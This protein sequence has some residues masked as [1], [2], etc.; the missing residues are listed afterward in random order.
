MSNKNN[1]VYN[2]Q[3]RLIQNMS[4]KIFEIIDK[5]EGARCEK[6]GE[7]R[8][9]ISKIE[10]CRDLIRGAYN[11]DKN[12]MEKLNI[13]LKMARILERK[14]EFRKGTDYIGSAFRK[15]LLI[16][17]DNNVLFPKKVKSMSFKSYAESQL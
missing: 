2:I 11:Y 14:N 12:K 9:V 3:G 13:Y 15:M 16:L 10:T 8:E 5:L 1:V 6:A 4:E 17:K 7:Y